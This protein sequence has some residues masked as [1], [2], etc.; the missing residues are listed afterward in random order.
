MIVQ[1]DVCNIPSV[2]MRNADMAAGFDNE[3]DLTLATRKKF[4]GMVSAE[5]M[6][7]AVYHFPFPC[8]GHVEKVGGNYQ[9]VPGV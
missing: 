2:F 9:L 7:I 1:G 4:F 8:M 6:L 3:P 5:K